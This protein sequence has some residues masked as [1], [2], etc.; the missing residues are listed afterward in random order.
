MSF[1]SALE[2][3]A[4]YIGFMFGAPSISSPL[5]APLAGGSL[6]ESEWTRGN[7]N[8]VDDDDDDAARRFWAAQ[9]WNGIDELQLGTRWTPDGCSH[10]PPPGSAQ[11][12][13]FGDFA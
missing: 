11:L 5:D 8:E 6:S 3:V 2:S 9:R 7:A 4:S 13:R 12:D 10:D 1:L